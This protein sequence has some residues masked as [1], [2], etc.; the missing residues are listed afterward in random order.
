MSYE[1]F[2]NWKVTEL[3]L[4]VKSHA[5]NQS[6]NKSS[7]VKKVLNVWRLGL[8]IESRLT[9]EDDKAAILKTQKSKLKIEGGLT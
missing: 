7:L 2:V 8:S 4:C 6:G 1:V 3:E 9:V 5:I